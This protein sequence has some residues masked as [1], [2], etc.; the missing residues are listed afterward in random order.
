MRKY[1]LRLLWKRE[2]ELDWERETEREREK[3][4]KTEKLIGNKGESHKND[5]NSVFWGKKKKQYLLSFS[6][7]PEMETFH[8]IHFTL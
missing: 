5:K 7:R 6:L 3:E 1:E 8:V 2:R 4:T